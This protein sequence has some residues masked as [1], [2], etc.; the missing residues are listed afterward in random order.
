[1]KQAV[2]IVSKRVFVLFL[3]A[4]LAMGAIGGTASAQKGGGTAPQIKLNGYQL[5]LPVDQRPFIA[6]GRILIPL[7]TIFERFGAQVSWDEKTR[8]ISSRMGDVTIRLQVNSATAFV[9]DKRVELD[10][11][12]ALVG[13][14]TFVPL[15]FISEAFGAK[16]SW[17]E[18]TRTAKIDPAITRV[19]APKSVD[20][21]REL[22]KLLPK[23]SSWYTAKNTAI[24]LYGGEVAE[25]PFIAPELLAKTAALRRELAASPGHVYVEELESWEEKGVS[26]F[27]MLVTV[28]EKNGALRRAGMDLIEV[29]QTAQ[30]E[31][32]VVTGYAHLPW[33]SEQQQSPVKIW[34][35][36]GVGPRE[37]SLAAPA[38][39]I[40]QN[41]KPTGK[42]RLPL[43]VLQS[44]GAVHAGSGSVYAVELGSGKQSEPLQTVTVNGMPYVDLESVIRALDGQKMVTEGESLVYRIDWRP[45]IG[46]LV[47]YVKELE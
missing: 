1:M 9:N 39:E 44:L 12:A 38:V 45:D 41:G 15:R 31:G 21:P 17:E 28:E 35:D 2:G 24:W 8:T 32:N 29:R 18:A 46:Q 3:T 11:P 34:L 43:A 37:I 19:P 5:S 22:Q 16:V 7:R 33:H 6:S 47:F 14:R 42:Y 20:L 4:A 36:A 27:R 10:Q 13:S 26:M 40:L 23:R 25:G 30:G